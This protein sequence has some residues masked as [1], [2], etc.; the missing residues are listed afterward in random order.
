ML[1]SGGHGMSEERLVK[2]VLPPDVFDDADEYLATAG[3]TAFN[4]YPDLQGLAMKHE[5]RNARTRSAAAKPASTRYDSF[6][7]F[8]A[9][10]SARRREQLRNR[11]NTSTSRA[12]WT[13]LHGSSGDPSNG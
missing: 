5:A 6:S 11:S 3:L 8:Y 1:P 4:F 13:P 2:I 10:V 12:A 7:A 9:T